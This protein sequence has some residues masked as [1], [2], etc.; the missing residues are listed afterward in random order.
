MSSGVD[1]VRQIKLWH[2]SARQTES[3][4]RP[5]CLSSAY[6]RPWGKLWS[7]LHL[8]SSPPVEL[9]KGKEGEVQRSTGKER[10]WK[11]S[12]GGKPEEVM[13]KK[14]YYCTFW[15]IQRDRKSI[16]NWVPVFKAAHLNCWVTSLRSVLITKINNVNANY[17]CI[18]CTV[19]EI[20]WI[21]FLK[22]SC[23]FAVD[24]KGWMCNQTNVGT[25]PPVVCLKLMS[26]RKNVWKC[27]MQ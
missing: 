13:E 18:T 22:L 14:D 25:N 17:N 23:F 26:P 16:E 21:I 5:V 3:D 20:N 7:V 2:P 8:L 27:L 12:R 10:E 4:I 11:T 6:L 15:C 19:R 1:C 9:P 24:V